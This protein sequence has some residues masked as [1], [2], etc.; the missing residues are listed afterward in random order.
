MQGGKRTSVSWGK[1]EQAPAISIGAFGKHPGW[2]DH[3]D[4]LGLDTD[5]LVRVR[6]KIY[7]EGVAGNIDSGAWEKLDDQQRLPGI[8]HELV[9]RSREGLVVGRLWASRDGKGR[10]KYP[11]AVVA[12]AAGV[13][14]SWVE[15]VVMPRLAE[16]ERACVATE[17]ADEV[18]RILDQARV[19]LR[20]ALPVQAQE[21]GGVATPAELAAMADAPELGPD[22]VGLRRALYEMERE[23]GAFRPA[24][25]DARRSTS[26]VI[27]V[28]AQHLRV[29]TCAPGTMAAA[30]LW[31]GVLSSQIDPT[32]DMVFLRPHA[33][34]WM[35]VIV[36]EPGAPQLFCFKA[37]ETGLAL[38]TSVPY[39][40]DADFV[41]RCDALVAAWKSG[42]LTA[43]E[44]GAPVPA[45]QPGAASA[46][47]P[48]KR[49]RPPW[50]LWG[51]AGAIVL[52]AGGAAAY[53]SLHGSGEA[54]VGPVAV[55]SPKSPA[56]PTTTTATEIAPEL[57]A[58]QEAT[59]D[60]LSP[61]AEETARLERERKVREEQDRVAK[62]KEAS[63]LKAS[64]ERALAAKE[65][66]DRKARE[67][68]DRVA[69]EKTAAAAKARDDQARLAKE[70][71][72][73]KA[74][75][76][77]DRLAKEAS[78]RKTRDDAARLAKEKEESDR[79]AAEERTR[80]A[81]EDAASKER[82]AGV[83]RERR[84]AVVK[85]ASELAGLLD[86]GYTLA[87]TTGA[88]SVG[89]QAAALAADPAGAQDAPEVTG[90][91]RRVKALETINASNDGAALAKQ[92]G[93]AG[94]G[95]L[96]EALT[97]WSRLASGG[98]PAW[99]SSA[100]DIAAGAES[101]GALRRA[102]G[103]GPDKVFAAQV[104]ARVDEQSRAVWASFFSRL[105]A[106][107]TDRIEAACAARAAFGVDVA[108]LPPRE[109]FNVA[110]YEFKR[111]A[112]KS[113]GADAA[114]A[115]A[116]AFTAQVGSIGPGVADRPE[117]IAALA[118]LAPPP[119]PAPA[120][121]G[122][123]PRSLGPGSRGWKGESRAQGGHPSI[124]FT[125]PAGD[126][127]ARTIEFVRVDAPSGP[128]YLCTTEV[129]VGLFVDAVD[130][131]AR[132]A[133]TLQTLRGF[134]KD[135]TP[136]V[137]KC[138][139][140]WAFDSAGGGPAQRIRT[141]D[142]GT[143]AGRGWIPVGNTTRGTPY[144]PEP[145][146]VLPPGEA[147]PMQCV[148]YLGAA[149]VANLLGC[150]L[151]SSAEWA[152]AQEINSGATANRR[153]ASWRREVEYLSAKDVGVQNDL[154][155]PDA[156]QCVPES[157]VTAAGDST[158]PFG[159]RAEA[160]VTEDDGAVWFIPVEQGTGLFKNLVGNVAE[161]TCENPASIDPVADPSVARLKAALGN[162]ESVRMIGAS[163]ISSRE[164]APTQA[165]PPKWTGP[166]KK[167]GFSDVGFRLAFS[168]VGANAVASGDG[169]SASAVVRAAVDLKYLSP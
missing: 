116:A 87:D 122:A 100:A 54:K 5:R 90:L 165:Y 66:S 21:L 67:E 145:N 160:A 151:P 68:Q 109:R 60:R 107:D 146:S 103:A 126:R 92:V 131:A 15:A 20:T 143:D 28:G 47:E 101:L 39:T 55:N 7:T 69:K 129:S 33:K 43:D 77:Q 40:L 115:R 118:A 139:R 34:A 65:E 102:L 111:D 138:P 159:K 35:D 148:N 14:A 71:S 72:D 17:S 110:L 53:L 133:D 162:G 127:P 95:H 37:S 108:S 6:Q 112:A 125:S 3:I 44:A 49:K 79:K 150:R 152:A 48:P 31:A 142:A 161:Y 153:D 70:E 141:A 32:A 120:A 11:M 1:A 119:A 12:H 147:S 155:W 63:D 24:K 168:A 123:D 59:K 58:R 136:D 105:G 22:R 23:L 96:A 50:M 13:S 81:A 140:T 29:P 83:V 130:A 64:Q 106:T 45:P 128:V 41:A 91:A 99:P 149:Y 167:G 114:R 117:V 113:A 75:E 132:W 27:T 157:M 154:I 163:A 85:R 57:K 46:S 56:V 38:V 61:K 25:G 88:G 8:G 52:L 86:A 19:D 166:A 156:G 51:G 76:E 30:G 93:A 36:G 98:V 78:D 124:V 62:E 104:A 16:V 158:Y 94:D 42:R 89:A 97:A 164:I 74:K 18:R 121:G 9:W 137:V 135:G 169:D 73:R 26:R 134:K 2:D 144:Y 80:L 4:D 10:T 84:A 82:E